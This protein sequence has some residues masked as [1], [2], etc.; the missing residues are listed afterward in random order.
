[1]IAVWESDLKVNLC[2]SLLK[3][4]RVSHLLW[5]VIPQE[6]TAIAKAALQVF[7]AWL[8]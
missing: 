6:S 1:M 7:S 8:R 4:D 3:L 5:K 2:I